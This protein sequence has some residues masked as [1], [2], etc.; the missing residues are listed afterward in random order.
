MPRITT[1]LRSLCRAWP[2]L[3]ALCCWPAWSQTITVRNSQL[4]VLKELRSRSEISEFQRHW[5]RMQ[6]TALNSADEH[7]W[8]YTV[9]IVGP[10]GASRWLYQ[11][12]GMAT[13]V[14]AQAQRVYKISNPAALNALIGAPKY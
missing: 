7:D 6:P 1:F 9:D 11:P 8:S 12:N 4:V 14:A 2:L 3:L 10:Q 5:S 13:R